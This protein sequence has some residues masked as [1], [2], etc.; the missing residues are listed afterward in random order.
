[1]PKRHKCS[2]IVLLKDRTTAWYRV[3]TL[4]LGPSANARTTRPTFETFLIERQLLFSIAERPQHAHAL[5]TTPLF[6]SPDLHAPVEHLPA[7]ATSNHDTTDDINESDEQAEESAPLLCYG[8]GNRLDVELDEDAGNVVLGDLVRLRGHGVLVGLDGVGGVEYV[9][10]GVVGVAVYGFE[11]GQEGSVV[12]VDG[13]HDGEVVLE[14]VEV[15]FGRGD[16]IVEGVDEGGVVGTEGHFL[17]VVREI[18]AWLW[19]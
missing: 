17:D 16:G 6:P 3:S 5:A 8:Q 19:C 1:M 7:P 10:G 4:V 12:G 9:L 11:E 14:F 13:G 2:H 15:V 18:E